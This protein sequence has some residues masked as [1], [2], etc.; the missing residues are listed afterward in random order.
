MAAQPIVGGALLRILEG[1]VGF[2]D[3]LEFLLGA[4]LLGN[5]RMV[6]PREL[7]VRLLDFLGAGLAVDAHHAVVVLVFHPDSRPL[8]PAGFFLAQASL[9][10]LGLRR[11]K[12]V[13]LFS[14]I[15]QAP[16]VILVGP[17]R[18]RD[19]RPVRGNLLPPPGVSRGAEDAPDD[20]HL[21]EFRLVRSPAGRSPSPSPPE[22]RRASPRPR[23]LSRS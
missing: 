11:V 22:A 18:L 23:Q 9:A 10:R 12:N 19:D 17:V 8:P 21:R 3:F 6:L 5:V 16:L 13:A 2:A 14:G 20:G 15:G 1:F 7:P 4:G